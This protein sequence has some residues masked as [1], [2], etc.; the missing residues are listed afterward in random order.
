MKLS[1]FRYK[2][3]VDLIAQHPAAERDKARLKVVTRKTGTIENKV[4]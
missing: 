4:F 3:P 1:Q 2:E